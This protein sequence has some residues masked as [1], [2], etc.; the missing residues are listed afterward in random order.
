M[1]QQA[2][3]SFG[4][5]RF[6][7]AHPLWLLLL[8]FV[9]HVAVRV[10]LSPALKWDAAEQMLWSQH[11]ALGYGPQPPLYTWLQWGVNQ[12]VG[13]G[14]LAVALLKQ[15]LIALAY[16]CMWLAARELLARRGAW[17]VAIS[18]MLLPTFGWRVFIDLSHTVLAMTMACALWAVVLPLVRAPRPWRFALLGAVCAGGLLAKYNF[19]LLIVALLLAALSQRDVRKALFAPGW[20][21][22]PLVGGLL[23]LP[24]A[25]WL[26]QH[27][28]GTADAVLARVDVGVGTGTLQR[29]LQIVQDLSETLGLFVLLALAV[30]GRAWWCRSADVPAAAGERTWALQLLWRTLALMVAFLLLMAYAGGIEH[31]KDRWLTPLLCMT[32]LACF[33]A[34]PG[35]QRLRRGRFYTGIIA[36]L[37]VAVVVAV[38]LRPWNAGRDGTPDLLAFPITELGQTLRAVG[39]HA[40]AEMGVTQPVLAGDL[41]TV[42]PQ[43]HVRLCNQSGEEGVAA[44]MM[45]SQSRAE[46]ARRG[47]LLLQCERDGPPDV[48]TGALASWPPEMRA[49]AQVLQLR[50]RFTSVHRPVFLQCRYSWRAGESSP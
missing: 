27:L 36:V 9:M 46:R 42:Y 30:F 33:A 32:P 19:A 40:Q 20:W 18:L 47:W 50:Y 6:S 39:V 16:L 26:L 44:C 31:Y 3:A 8:F 12:L 48:W 7:L 38:A 34:R 43:A 5:P 17:W 23:V 24:H 15:S 13:P 10:A 1:V 11:L 29:L 35:L 25:L 14:V 37:A 28:Q 45:A 21:W 2:L 22:A 4:R 49:R 41:R